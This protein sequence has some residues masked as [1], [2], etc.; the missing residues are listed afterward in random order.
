M[1]MPKTIK[2]ARRLI[3]FAQSL[4]KIIPNLA[5]KLQPFFKVLRKENEFLRTVEH[6]TILSTIKKDLTK[7]CEL[8][9]KM[10]KPNCQF[11]IVSDASF[12]AAGFTFLI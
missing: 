11:V 9:L 1:R 6:K 5:I 3:G 2:Q 7:A 4:Q 12:Y 8:S 10:A